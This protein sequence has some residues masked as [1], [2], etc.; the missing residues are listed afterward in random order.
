MQAIVYSESKAPEYAAS[1]R[2]SEALNVENLE[3]LIAFPTR[4]CC[5]TKMIMK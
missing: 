3:L 4:L 5:I 1:K 2:S